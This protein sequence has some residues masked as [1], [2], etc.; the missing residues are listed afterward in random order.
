MRW[1]IAL[2]A[3][4][5]AMLVANGLLVYFAVAFDDPVVSSYLTEKR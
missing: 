3:G 2:I 1:T 4:F 5:V